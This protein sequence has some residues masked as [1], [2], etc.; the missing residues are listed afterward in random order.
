MGGFELKFLE[1][2]INLFQKLFFLM[3]IL[4]ATLDAIVEL[5]EGLRLEECFAGA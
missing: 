2:S 4:I 1:T 3:C 5:R